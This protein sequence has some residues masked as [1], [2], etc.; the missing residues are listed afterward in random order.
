VSPPIRR[1]WAAWPAVSTHSSVTV[2][3]GRWASWTR[4]STI[5]SA[6][7][8]AERPHTVRELAEAAGMSQ[9]L[10]SHHLARLREQGLVTITPKGS[11][12]VYAPCC[13]AL[14]GAVRLLGTLAARTP[15]G[16]QACCSG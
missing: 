3:P 13:E 5:A 8:L 11:S 2:S 10:V 7:G 6:A 9:T 15:E 4:V 1:S 14:A 16:A 12:N